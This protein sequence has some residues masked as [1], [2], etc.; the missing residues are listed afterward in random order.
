MVIRSGDMPDS[1][2]RARRLGPFC[3]MLCAAPA[4]LQ[5]RGEPRRPADLEAHEC[6]HYRFA[7]SGKVQE[8]SLRLEPG[9]SPPH[10]PSA[11]VCN[12][13]E[14]A[15][16]AAVDG[17]TA[18]KPDGEG[19]AGP[20][21]MAISYRSFNRCPPQNHLRPAVRMTFTDAKRRR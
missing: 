12:N 10:L 1:R 18:G 15:V 3:F 2:L 13:I 5:R 21:F 14:A 20:S 6:I 7:N 16:S 8:W 9:E 4:Y 11:L 19:P 17:A